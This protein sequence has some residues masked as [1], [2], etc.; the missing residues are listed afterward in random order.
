MGAVTYPDPTAAA[1]LNER[2]IQVQVNIEKVPKSAEN[3]QALLTPNLSKV[4]E[5]EK[6]IYHIE[7]WLSPSECAAMLSIAKATTTFAAIISRRFSTSI[8]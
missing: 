1:M 2:F 8:L 5:K 3:F 6:V 4:N 7:G